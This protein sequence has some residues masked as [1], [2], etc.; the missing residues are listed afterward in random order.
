MENVAEN[1]Y[2]AQTQPNTGLCDVRFEPRKNN[3]TFLCGEAPTWQ[4]V[5]VQ[6]HIQ[7]FQDFS[8]PPGASASPL[9]NVTL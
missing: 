2:G 3:Y 7:I 4:G 5:K 9:E 6:A 8:T 1:R